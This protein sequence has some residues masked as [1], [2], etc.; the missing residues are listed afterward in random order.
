MSTQAKKR[1]VALVSSSASSVNVRRSRL[2]SITRQVRLV[3]GQAPRVQHLDPV[4][5]D[6]AHDDGWP[7]SAKQAPVTRPTQPAPKIPIAG[8]SV[9]R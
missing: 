5:D 1:S 3:E 7:R 9:M 2:R 4:R 8:F 6:V